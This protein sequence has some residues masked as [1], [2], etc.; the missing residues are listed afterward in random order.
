[1][2]ARGTEKEDMNGVE[3]GRMQWDE[4]WCPPPPKKLYVETLILI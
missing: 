1:M 4:R 2:N 3:Q